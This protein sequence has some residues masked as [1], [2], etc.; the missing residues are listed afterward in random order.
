M[1][2]AD[3]PQIFRMLDVLESVSCSRSV[4]D[5]PISQACDQDKTRSPS[6]GAIAECPGWKPQHW[7]V[8]KGISS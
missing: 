7:F 5:D 3:R 2:M 1:R 4:S 8:E 6:T